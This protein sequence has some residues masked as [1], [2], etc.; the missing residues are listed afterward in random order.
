MREELF[1]ENLLKILNRGKWEMSGD[2]MQVFVAVYNQAKKQYDISKEPKTALPA[3][4]PVEAP[5]KKGKK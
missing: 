5:I 1:W 4:K 3:P 2:E